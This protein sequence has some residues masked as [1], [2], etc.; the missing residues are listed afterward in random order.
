MPRP[1]DRPTPEAPA[2]GPDA[3][4]AG[5]SEGGRGGTEREN[6]HSR[7]VVDRGDD[8]GEERLAAAVALEP[9]TE[10]GVEPGLVEKP[11]GVEALGRLVAVDPGGVDGEVPE[12]EQGGDGDDRDQDA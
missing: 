10:I 8:I 4:D 12:A 9:D 5:H 2:E 7:E 3:D 6:G 1:S 11:R